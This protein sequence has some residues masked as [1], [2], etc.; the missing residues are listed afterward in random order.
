VLAAGP[1][2][3]DLLP[4]LRAHLTL[5]RQPLVWFRPKD[6]ELVKG[7]RMPV[8]SLQT[9]NDLIY[10]FPDI[11]GTGVKTASHLSGG[12]MSRPDGP[13]SEVSAGE[14]AALRAVLERYVPAAAG[15][16]SNETTCIYTR[17]SDGHFVLG[18]HPDKPQIVLASP[19]SGHGFKFSSI[20]GEV[21]A[22]LATTQI[23]NKLID[24]FRPSRFVKASRP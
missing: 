1:W 9:E 11:F 20:V 5:T 16:S 12:G 13:R 4:E 10:G 18:L 14:K 23:T 2:I 24:L 7:D 8:F 22:D 17:T 15:S 6:P 21:L 3:A 19:C